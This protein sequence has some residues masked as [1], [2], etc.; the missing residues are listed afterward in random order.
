MPKVIEMKNIDKTYGSIVKTQVLFDLSLDFEE[1]SFNSIIGQS[2]SGK[3]TLLNIMGTLDTP[4]R[5]EV[6]IDGTNTKGMSKNQLSKL[7][8][9]TIGF[10]F[11]FH[12]LLPE[13][14]ALENVLMPYRIKKVNPPKEVYERANELLDL[15]GL[16]NVKNNLSTMMS[17]GQ[18]QRTA[19]ARALINNPKIILADEP[20]GNLDSESTENIYNLLREI[21]ERYKTTFIIITHDKKI[22]EKADRIVE[23]KDGIINMDIRK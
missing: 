13:F 14:T 10:I 2:G 15:L 16:N 21:N 12:Y 23:I 17:G 11:Q 5:G 6:I 18:Q 3:S 20:T 4:T 9:E 1:G 19:I 8:N 22:A 7:R